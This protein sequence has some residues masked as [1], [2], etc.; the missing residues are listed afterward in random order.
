MN[1]IRLLGVIGALHLPLTVAL[2]DEVDDVTLNLFNGSVQTTDL[3]AVTPQNREKV[4]ERLREIARHPSLEFN[5][6]IVQGKG[7]KVLLLRLYDEP[8]MQRVIEMFRTSRGRY[9]ENMA[10]IIT[11]ANQ[12]AMIP[13]LAGELL[14]DGENRDQMHVAGGE[15]YVISPKSVTAGV[16][17]RDIVRNNDA[18]SPEVKEWMLK[19]YVAYGSGRD[20][21]RYRD[22]MHRWWKQNEE[23]FRKKEYGLVAPIESAFE[24]QPVT[25]KAMES[26]SPPILPTPPAPTQVSEHSSA[27]RHD[28]SPATASER[29]APMWV[30]AI[31]L[32][33]LAL[34]SLLVWKRRS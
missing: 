8:T 33:A 31:G 12:P 17:I 5:H 25:S 26:S 14:S 3:G 18:F 22:V 24:P 1:A 27:T 10:D 19:A 9:I 15:G 20:Y 32:S 29:T 2:G 23:H 11:W 4:V 21:A 16:A 30:W 34:I 6:A 13:Y 28:K 7:A